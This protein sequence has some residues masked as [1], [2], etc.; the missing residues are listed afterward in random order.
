MNRVRQAWQSWRRQLI[1]TFSNNSPTEQQWELDLAKGD[2][3]GHFGPDSAVWAVHGSMTPIVAGIRALLLQ[4]LHPGALAGVHDYSNYQEDPLGR[5]AGTIRWIFTVTYGDT[6]AARNGSQW[7]RRLHDRVQ[8]RYV[9][10]DGAPRTY[11]ANDPEI[12]RWVHL[13]FT[14]AFLTSHLAF[15]GPIPGGAD[16]YVDEWAV[17]GELMGIPDPPR[18]E[19]QLRAQMAAFDG[20]LYHSAYLDEVLGFLRNP[21]LPASQRLGYR[22]LFAGA[23][24]T[25]TPAHRR[26]LGLRAPQLGPVPI[27]MRLPVKAVL[28]VIRLGLG[29][30]GPSER[31]ARERIA[32]LQNLP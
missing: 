29:A 11:A 10:A 3:V 30:Q 5:L 28:G 21:P 7:V 32:R 2:D 8:G 6:A 27:P 1:G 23:V 31:S 13:A 24:S 14:D 18:S 20:E 15:G 4:A 22:V 25:L 26:L 9:D 17:A 12:G 19:A 16:R